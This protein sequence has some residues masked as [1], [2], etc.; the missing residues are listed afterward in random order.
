MDSENIN[1]SVQELRRKNKNELM[2]R[3]A[4]LEK[5]IHNC[6]RH[7]TLKGHMQWVSDA[8]ECNDIRELLGMEK[9]FYSSHNIGRH[10]G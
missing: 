7:A 1:F 10:Q 9:S 5:D 2:D 6:Q 3:L 8:V 4:Y